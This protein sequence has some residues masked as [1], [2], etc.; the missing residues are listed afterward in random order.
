[1]KLKLFIATA[2]AAVAFTNANAQLIEA[3]RLAENELFDAANKA[4]DAVI[5]A[6][7]TNGEAYYYYGKTLMAEQD[8]VLAEKMFNKGIAAAP[9]NALNFIGLASIKMAEGKKTEAQ[10]SIDN[11][12]KIGDPKNITV[13]VETASALLVGPAKDTAQAFKLIDKARTLDLG[14]DKKPKNPDVYIV[15]GDVFLEG[16]SRNDKGGMAM[17]AYETAKKLDKTP[18]RALLRAGNLWMRARQF[19][20]ALKEY[21][22]AVKVDS[23]FAPAYRE[24]GDFYNYF[25]RY[26][27]AIENYKK[28]LKLVKDDFKAR[29]IYAKALYKA[30]RWADAVAE[31]DEIQKVDTSVTVLRRLLA[32]SQYETR[33]Y[34]E[35]LKNMQRFLEVHPKDKIIPLDYSYLGRLL[36]K[37][38]QDSLA[39]TYLLD[40]YGKDTSAREL[41]RDI[42]EAF[43]NLKK[44]D[45]AVKYFEVRTKLANVTVRDWINLGLCHYRL[46]DFVKA[47]E[48]FGNAIGLQPESTEAYLRRAQAKSKL[49][50]ENQSQGLAKPYYETFISKMKPDQAEKNK[51][52]M[53]EAY[54]YLGSYY[55]RVAKDFL[56]AKENYE[57]ILVYDPESVK[58]KDAL[59]LPEL[60]DLVPVTPTPP[61]PGN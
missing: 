32:Y 16:N 12:L 56:K 44:Y 2:F 31:I 35:G 37:N 4:F 50:D 36:S 58:A 41:S 15:L 10:T 13:L 43:L 55:L 8:T 38:G 29:V 28:Y 14:K 45:E 52:S 33:K 54:L 20:A 11:A 7:P 9:T 26:N 61:A 53:A 59:L 17:T 42:G 46:K 19:E 34:P 51:K 25:T 39:L 21:K 1:M 22:D 18:T 47:D 3:K 5:A 57:K 23:T 30:K 60:K 49:D 48:A 6:E 40:V 24:M 27:L